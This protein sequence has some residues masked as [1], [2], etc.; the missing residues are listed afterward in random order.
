M[1]KHP[2]SNG[3]EPFAKSKNII[4]QKLASILSTKILNFSYS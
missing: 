3:Y 2:Q 1:H 4:Y